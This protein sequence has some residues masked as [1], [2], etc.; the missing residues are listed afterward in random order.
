M[1]IENNLTHYCKYRTK[2]YMV[3]EF[4]KNKELFAKF[5][6]FYKSFVINLKVFSFQFFFRCCFLFVATYKYYM[7]LVFLPLVFH[8]SN[9]AENGISLIL[10]S[11]VSPTLYPI[12]F[13]SGR[14]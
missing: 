4:K 5:S 1:F 8:S 12:P 6:Y 14:K 11:K 9:S 7:P 10:Y 13:T 3:N 2:C